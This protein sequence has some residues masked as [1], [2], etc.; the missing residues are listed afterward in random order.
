MRT[1]VV[2]PGLV[3]WKEEKSVIKLSITKRNELYM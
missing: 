1:G 2:N 3:C